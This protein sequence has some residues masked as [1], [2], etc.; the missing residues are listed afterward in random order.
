[1]PEGKWLCEENEEVLR[2]R[3]VRQEM[4][5]RFK[6]SDELFA[7]VRSLEK[8]NGTRR[9]KARTHAKLRPVVSRKKA[10]NR[11]TVHKA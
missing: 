1:M 5:S 7:W 8:Q 11:K 2:L 4:Y 10:S 3:K 6:N 9:G